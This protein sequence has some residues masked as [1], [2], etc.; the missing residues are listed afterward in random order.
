M[1][2]QDAYAMSNVNIVLFRVTKPFR[3][4]DTCTVL[5]MRVSVLSYRCGQKQGPAMDPE[6]VEET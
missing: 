6:V 1:H 4:S 5:S 3:Y 2:K